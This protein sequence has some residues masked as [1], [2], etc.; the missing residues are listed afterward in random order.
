MDTVL[1][2]IVRAVAVATLLPAF[3]IMWY[4][5][6]SDDTPRNPVAP[7]LGLAVF[8]A[9]VWA[10]VTAF[11]TLD[12]DVSRAL[13][14]FAVAPAAYLLAWPF[15]GNEAIGR[16]SLAEYARDGIWLAGPLLLGALYAAA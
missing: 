5:T 11:R 2:W 10:T 8:A 6:G 3:F 7:L 14:I 12:D 16:L 13:A 9:S 15:S 4:L 1:V